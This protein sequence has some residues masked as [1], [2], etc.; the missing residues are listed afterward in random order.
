MPVCVVVIRGLHPRCS[1]CC[2]A[3]TVGSWDVERPSFVQV[4]GHHNVFELYGVGA[5]DAR[6]SW[7]NCEALDANLVSGGFPDGAH[8]QWWPRAR[9]HLDADE[10][11]VLGA[12]LVAANLSTTFR[13]RKFGMADGATYPIQ[14]QARTTPPGA[15]AC[16]APA[17]PT[18]MDR[19]HYSCICA[20]HARR[21]QHACT[22][23]CMHA[24]V[25]HAVPCA[26]ALP[27]ICWANREVQD[28][29]CVALPAARST[30][31]CRSECSC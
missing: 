20:K 26:P 27:F 8:R 19:R 18:Q 7:G 24:S 25:A 28:M 15:S 3:E 31:T 16:C 22:H 4:R 12:G 21:C 2:A 6:G 23:A 9:R 17:V 1:R 11:V 5:E 13:L 30:V 14:F 10:A 29:H